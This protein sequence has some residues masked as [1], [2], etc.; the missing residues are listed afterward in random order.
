M[1]EEA[2]ECALILLAWVIL[3]SYMDF[4]LDIHLSAD[5]GDLKAAGFILCVHIFGRVIAFSERYRK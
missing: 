2:K 4:V 5:Y 1:N 3:F